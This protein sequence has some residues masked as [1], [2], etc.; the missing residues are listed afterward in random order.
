MLGVGITMLLNI[1]INA[2]IL[3]I[4][5]IEMKSVLPIQYACMLVFISVFLTVI[6]GLIPSKFAAKKDPAVVLRS[7]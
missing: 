7:E 6:A 2:I 3:K 4:T 5:Q 1:P